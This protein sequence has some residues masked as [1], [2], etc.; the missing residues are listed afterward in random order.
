M[1]QQPAEGFEPISYQVVLPLSQSTLQMLAGLI[2]THRRRLRSRWRKAGPADQALVVLAVL[3]DDQRLAHLG[4]GMGVSA[5]TVRRW[6]LEA[7][8]LLAARATRLNRVLRRQ[9]ARG[10]E[11]V[12]VD[13][14]LIRTR[15]RTGKANR[16]NY[17]GKH[18]HHGLVV[19]ALTDENGRLLWVSAA[20]PGK[21]ADITAARRLRIRERLHTYGLSP[22]GDKGFHGWHKD[23]RDSS[24]CDTCGG[25]CEHVVLTPYKAE[26][27]RPLSKA[28]KQANAVF[29][30]MRCAVEG[31]FAALKAWRI[32]GKLRLDTRHATTLLRALLVLT[33][34]E[35][36]IRDAAR[37]D[38]A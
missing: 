21:T 3:R 25:A 28:Q 32:L 18:K 22:A 19:L 24:A 13:G 23:V 20:L 16:A 36:S 38:P 5:S 26:T 17:N 14:T 27:R 6:V 37:P 7:I 1:S 33:Q 4:G 12:L 35:Q 2:R 8:T 10:A 9:A 31:G 29:A 34:H 11:V 30:A 15:R